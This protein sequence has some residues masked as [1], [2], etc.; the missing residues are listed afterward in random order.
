MD[1]ETL[2]RTASYSVSG[3][4]IIPTIDFLIKGFKKHYRQEEYSISTLSVILTVLTLGAPLFG[5]AFASLM[6][7]MLFGS[8][9]E[10]DIEKY[11]FIVGTVLSLGLI[12]IVVFIVLGPTLFAY[13]KILEGIY[14]TEE[15][16]PAE[17]VSLLI[18]T[19]IT[20]GFVWLAIL[21]NIVI[22][23]F[24]FV[25]IWNNV[26]NKNVEYQEVYTVLFILVS[27]LT[28]GLAPLGAFLTYWRIELFFNNAE[29]Q[30][31]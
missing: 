16:S 18:A 2:V 22:H 13:R 12:W 8:Q 11:G 5:Y 20:L 14:H 17:G 19:I 29:D 3:L 6:M 26:M 27:I 9:E 25:R 23:R 15:P 30:V 28:L 21:I 24:L 31:I 4:S 7:K 1:S 10:Y